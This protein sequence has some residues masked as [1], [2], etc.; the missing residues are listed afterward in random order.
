[1][2]FWTKMTK[3]LHKFTDSKVNG[4]LTTWRKRRGAKEFQLENTSSHSKATKIRY[5]CWIQKYLQ[6]HV[7]FRFR[8]HIGQK[9]LLKNKPFFYKSLFYWEMYVPK[10]NIN[11][12]KLEPTTGKS[13]HFSISMIVIFKMINAFFL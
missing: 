5:H 6:Y 12:Y 13:F 8:C 10:E 2:Y 4:A 7:S 1:M 9:S 11:M 3:M